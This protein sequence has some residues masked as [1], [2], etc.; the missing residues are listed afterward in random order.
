MSF[1]NRL[2]GNKSDSNR[3]LVTESTDGS[4]S[5]LDSPRDPNW[6]WQEQERS[7]EGF[8]LRELKWKVNLPEE[9]LFLSAK[10]VRHS[11]P[12]ES[13]EELLSKDW[14]KHYAALFG[15]VTTARTDQCTQT[16]MKSV[17]PACNVYLEGTD[18]SR[19][20]IR[21]HERH[22]SKPG[23]AFLLSAYGKL[24]SFDRFSQDVDR[25]FASA[26]FKD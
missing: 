3:I 13:M 9:L 12:P 17:I 8:A 22:S 15:T 6:A 26:T 14:A 2:F 7:G 24:T 18:K 16:L 21:L 11:D 5:V 25:F 10:Y 1:I 23:Y 4:I 19:I 20:P